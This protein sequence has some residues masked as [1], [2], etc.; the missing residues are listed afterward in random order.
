MKT[1][2]VTFLPDKNGKTPDPQK[3]SAGELVNVGPSYVFYTDGS[4]KNIVAAFAMI[5]VA[6]ITS[7]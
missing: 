5:L 7:E 1:Y 4:R 6:T 3:V 2:I